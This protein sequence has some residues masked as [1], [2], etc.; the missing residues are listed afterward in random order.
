MHEE[1]RTMN[2]REFQE[3]V[4]ATGSSLLKAAK[5]LGIAESTVTRWGDKVPGYAEWYAKARKHIPPDAL[6]RLDDGKPA[7]ADWWWA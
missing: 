4:R 2:K 3:Q 1:R 5:H 7:S 6:A